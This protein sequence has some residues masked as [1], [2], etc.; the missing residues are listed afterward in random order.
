MYS[1]LKEAHLYSPDFQLQLHIAGEMTPWWPQIK[2]SSL[3]CH[4]YWWDNLPNHISAA[5]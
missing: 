4:S 5:I 2:V 3:S 1:H